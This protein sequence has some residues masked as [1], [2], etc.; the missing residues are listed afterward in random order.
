MVNR[1][2]WTKGLLICGTTKKHLKTQGMI[3]HNGGYRVSVKR[4]QAVAY[5]ILSASLSLS[6]IRG[7]RFWVNVQE[8]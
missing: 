7:H 2:C 6:G 8:D 5:G 3:L 4:Q 1:L